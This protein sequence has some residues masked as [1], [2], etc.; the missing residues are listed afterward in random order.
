MNKIKKKITT[1][2]N[3]TKRRCFENI[4][5]INKT[6]ARFTVKKR[7]KTHIN[8]IEM[9]GGRMGKLGLWG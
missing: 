6:L 1:K 7:E 2:V 3:E 5:K 4:N 9:K 8:K